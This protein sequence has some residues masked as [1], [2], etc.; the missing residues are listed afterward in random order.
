[1][2]PE[3]IFQP[4]LKLHIGADKGTGLIHSVETTAANVHDITQPAD[5]LHVEDKVVHADAGY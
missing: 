3:S 4:T 5:L 2:R 1:M